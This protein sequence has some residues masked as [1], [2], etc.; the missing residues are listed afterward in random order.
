MSKLGIQYVKYSKM[1]VAGKYTGPKSIG[2]LVTFNGT[3]NKSEVE[4]WGD[5]GIVESDKSVTKIALSMELNDLA[6][7]VYADLC[8]H[9]YDE[10]TKKVTVKS[11]DNSPYV[12]IGAIG[13]SVRS[14]V[15]VFVLKFYPKMQ[16]SD[17]TDENG[18]GKE[19]KEYKHTTIEGVGYPDTVT[20]EIKIEQEF[21]TLSAAVT[22]LDAL[23]KAPASQG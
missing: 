15:E 2:T 6:G 18:T 7:A 4:D 19:T 12:G 14:G 3:P 1:D 16:F 8:G 21:D 20:K 13:N 5:N 9:D 23:L 22:A 17:P 10:E 11:T